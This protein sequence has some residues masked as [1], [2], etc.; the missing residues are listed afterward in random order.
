M[1]MQTWSVAIRVNGLAPQI[2]RAAVGTCL[3]CEA[4]ACTSARTRPPRD[5]STPASA[6]LA[7][8]Q[9]LAAGPLKKRR[10]SPALPG[11]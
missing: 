1:M 3:R 10:N 7:Q 4:P 9:V 6:W 2:P 5:T 8:G 11:Y